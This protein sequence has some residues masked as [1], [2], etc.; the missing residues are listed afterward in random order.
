MAAS[1]YL[2]LVPK[3]DPM[4]SG[5]P[6]LFS[7]NAFRGSSTTTPKSTDGET[8]VESSSATGQEEARR[9]FQTPYSEG[10]PTPE[11]ELEDGKLRMAR[12]AIRPKE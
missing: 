1:T 3:D 7:V 2:G 6:E 10:G 9:I 8:P 5:G 12:Y 4:F 11:E